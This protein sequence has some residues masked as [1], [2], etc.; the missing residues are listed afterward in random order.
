M[1]L[2]PVYQLTNKLNQIC[3]LKK[4][5]YGL[6]QLLRAWFGRFNKAMIDLKY[7]QAR[8]N[9]TL[10]IK[11]SV[12]GT[13]TVLLIY[14]DEILITRGDV[15]EVHRL[16]KALSRQFEMKELGQLKYFLGIEVA[17]SKEDISLRQHKYTLDL[18]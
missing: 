6:K 4:A 3:K 17:Y 16:T 18:L 15:E 14:I 1:Q 12:T 8:G 2:P 11:H 5:P 7:H 10:F 9:H 13:I